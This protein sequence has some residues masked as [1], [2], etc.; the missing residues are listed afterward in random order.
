MG[1]ETGPRPMSETD[2]VVEQR[3]LG[4]LMRLAFKQEELCQETAR[5]S[6]AIKRT[7]RCERRTDPPD[8]HLWIITH[9]TGDFL[10]EPVEEGGDGFMDDFTVKES[11]ESLLPVA[12]VASHFM[13]DADKDT[14][15]A[16]G[17]DKRTRVEVIGPNYCV[18]MRLNTQ[19]P[20]HVL[21]K[22]EQIEEAEQ[23][24]V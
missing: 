21:Q 10:F 15:Y 23:V 3:R 22:I 7:L 12:Y 4:H 13:Y 2:Q 1:G 17:V 8:D 9:D 14:L 24:A 19:L 18:G 5:V 11:S 20:V 6:E 16:Y